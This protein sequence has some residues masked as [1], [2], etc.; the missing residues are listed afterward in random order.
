MD[1]D[2][3]EQTGGAL[4]QHGKANNRLYL[5][6]WDGNE[7]G[8]LLDTINRLVT[9]NGYTKVFA[10]VPESQAEFFTAQ[11]FEEEA[12]IPT[13]YDSEACIF[14][15]KFVEA[16]R[17][18]VSPD[19][20]ETMDRNLALARGRKPEAVPSLADGYTLR[21]LT[22]EDCNQLADLYK[23]VFQT[24]PFPV[25]DPAYLE[26]TMEEHI[27]YFGVFSGQKLVAASSAEMDEKTAS[28]EFTDFATNPE[29]RGNSFA[30]ILL[31][32]MQ[33]A[34]TERGITTQYTIARALSAGM[35]ITFAKA[36]YHYAGT[37][38]NNTDISGTIES[39]NV[40]YR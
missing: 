30:S 19:I 31:G 7:P 13:Y 12:R 28:V 14:M 1:Y 24:Y 11:N 16:A 37:L 34:M 4:F 29:Y 9:G 32:E 21:E 22:S 6:K 10:K 3:I 2:Q 36:G 18:K 40:W 26:E 33:K 23:L 17:K 25:H 38:V 20:Q 27:V 5:M 8:K 35:N 15:G 39:M